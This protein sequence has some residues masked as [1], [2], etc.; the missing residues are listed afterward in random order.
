MVCTFLIIPLCLFG[1]A[2][3]LNLAWTYCFTGVLISS[4]V[5]PIVLSIFWARV[6]AAGS[7]ITECAFISATTIR[8]IMLLTSGM[9]AGAVCGCACGIMSWLITASNYE[10]G[11][12]LDKF[13]ENT[14]KVSKK[15]ILKTCFL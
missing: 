6:T 4:S 8:P 13:V 15:V 11:L 12:A 10:G 1:W 7:M 2:V 14:G 3:N 5:V 9:I